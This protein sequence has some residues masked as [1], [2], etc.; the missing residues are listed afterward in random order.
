VPLVE[1]AEVARHA[2]GL[3]RVEAGPP[4]VEARLARHEEQHVVV[5]P[6]VHDLAYGREPDLGWVVVIRAVDGVVQAR[7][8]APMLLGVEQE[9]EQAILT[10]SASRRNEAP[11]VAARPSHAL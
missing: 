5:Y 1:V 2:R 8:P 4:L 6:Q 3:V 10:P 11:A 7:R 9:V